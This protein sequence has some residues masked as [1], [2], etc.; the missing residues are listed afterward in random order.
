MKIGKKT[1]LLGTL[2]LLCSLSLGMQTQAKHTN[3]TL[4]FEYYYYDYG[5]PVKLFDKDGFYIAKR[6]PH[7]GIIVDGDIEGEI[8]Y[9]GN[10]FLDLATYNG[11]GGGIIEFTGNFEGE[12]AGFKG[13]LKFKV[14]GGAISGTLNCPGSGAFTGLL[15]KG[16]FVAIL[17][18]GNTYVDLVIWNK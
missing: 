1:I 15:F 3:E 9:N 12:A 10:I 13:V 7:Y 2:L 6:T 16:T 4:S 11:W 18:G 5:A 17:G 8:Y 14:V